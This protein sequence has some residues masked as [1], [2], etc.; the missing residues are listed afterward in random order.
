MY[1]RSFAEEEEDMVD[2]FVR[3]R[4]LLALPLKVSQIGL[5]SRRRDVIQERDGRRL[6]T[7]S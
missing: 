4:L 7:S 5:A 2:A 3:E 6:G 1:Q